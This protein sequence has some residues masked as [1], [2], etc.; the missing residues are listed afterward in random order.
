[1]N[2]RIQPT[3]TGLINQQFILE[4]RPVGP[5][6]PENWQYREE[7]V[8][9]PAEGQILIRTRYISV[10]PAMRGWASDARSYMKPVSLGDPMRAMGV[11]D[12]IA[13][14]NPQIPVGR[15]LW[16]FM[17][18]Q[19]YCVIEGGD[20]MPVDPALA[21]IPKF[22]GVLG[23]PGMTAYFGLLEIGQPQ[24]GET[25]VV[26]GA[27]GAVGQ[28][29]GQIAKIRGCRAVGIAGGPDKC[30][31]VI[32]ELGFD[33]CVDYKNDDLQFELYDACRD[34]ID[35]YFDN[36]G[37]DILDTVLTR[38]NSRARIVLSGAMSQY[39]ATAP[40]KGPSNYLSLL[41]N[42]AR[43]EGFL[44]P[45]Y[46]SRRDESI[47]QFAQWMAE[48]KLKSREHIVQGIEKFPDTLLR[49]FSGD[50]LGKL[51]IEVA[52]E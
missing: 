29:V 45:D 6:R 41:A 46:L 42:R 9:E 28:L 3:G 17:G 50:H 48:G 1:M 4:T 2:D 12:V 40:V 7:P 44:A 18:V 49:L 51:I 35:V 36:V 26:S 8:P 15:M 20:L 25:I 34:G 43:M 13:S 5:L 24:P 10:D 16:G 37:G 21:P 30:R 23:I 11:G 32:E 39:N 33:A 27:S 52:H 31:F 14:R 47:R 22:L 19:S 38:I